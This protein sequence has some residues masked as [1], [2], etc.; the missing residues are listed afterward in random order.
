MSQCVGECEFCSEDWTGVT[1]VSSL[2]AQINPPTQ[3]HVQVHVHLYL[4]HGSIVIIVNI[5]NATVCTGK[6]WIID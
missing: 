5:A 6:N 4:Y 1:G 2:V 3:V